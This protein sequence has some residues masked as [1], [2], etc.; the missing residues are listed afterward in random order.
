MWQLIK[1]ILKLQSII[2]CTSFQNVNETVGVY[3]LCTKETHSCLLRNKKIRIFRSFSSNLGLQQSLKS[4]LGVLMEWFTSWKVV[5]NLIA[6]LLH[7]TDLL[8]NQNALFPAF[9]APH[10]PS[11]NT[12]KE[13]ELLLNRALYSIGTYYINCINKML[14][15]RTFTLLKSVPKFNTLWI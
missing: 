5:T 14:G 4:T 13:D 7:H 3:Q 6:T 9:A 15:N 10:S 2:R 12:G 11:G 1:D 8:Q